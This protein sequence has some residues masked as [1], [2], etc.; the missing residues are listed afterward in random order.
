MN[1]FFTCSVFLH[2]I[3][4]IKHRDG[5]GER[6]TLSLSGITGAGLGASCGV[7]DV[8]PKFKDILMITGFA[9]EEEGQSTK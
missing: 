1:H 3:L 6:S 8:Q 4:K 5:W 9:G 7:T 2:H